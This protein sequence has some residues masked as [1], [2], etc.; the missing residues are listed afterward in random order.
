VTAGVGAL[1]RTVT[2]SRFAGRLNTQAG[3]A[4]ALVTPDAIEIVEIGRG[5]DAS[6]PMEI[7]SLTKVFTALLL[8]EAIERGEL[9]LSDRID[10][11]LFGVSWSGTPAITVGEL[12]THTSGL[13]RLSFN[14]LAALRSD[15]YLR[16]TRKDLL[17]YL[18]RTRPRR[19]ST[20]AFSYSNLGY[21]VLGLVLEKASSKALPCLLEDRVLTPLGM[22]QTRLQLAAGGD[23]AQGGLKASGAPASL[24]HWDAYAPC[25]AMV[26]TLED[27]TLA[28]R[29]F[30]DQGSPI[31]AALALTTE[32][33]APVPGGSVGLAWML[34]EAGNAFW[35]N[36]ATA[37]YSSYLGVNRQRGMAAIVLASQALPTETTELG[38]ALMRQIRAASTVPDAAE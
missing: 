13:P 12:A 2:G 9:K 17:D 8:A 27:L 32:P 1:Q 23:L 19:P 29:G 5:V 20:G 37:G 35:H 4:V 22:G 15:P 28:A 38:T 18:D 26:S 7:G 30:L 11:I 25:G 6:T 21:A 24:W 10:E 16:Y 3:A 14:L 33:R 34:P 31:A 36:G